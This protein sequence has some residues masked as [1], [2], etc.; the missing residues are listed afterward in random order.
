MP[1]PFKVNL[2]RAK[3]DG[4]YHREGFFKCNPDKRDW[5]K[6]EIAR[7]FRKLNGIRCFKFKDAEGGF[8]WT[9]TVK[10]WDGSATEFDNEL[11]EL[12]RFAYSNGR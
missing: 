3:D 1:K 2:D 12:V 11:K 5:G 8:H 9:L 4:T 6:R 10:K 7:W